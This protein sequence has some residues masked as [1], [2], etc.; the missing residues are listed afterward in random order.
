MIYDFLADA[1]ITTWSEYLRMILRPFSLLSEASKA[2]GYVIGQSTD[3]SRIRTEQTGHPNF[4]M[5]DSSQ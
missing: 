3:C 5:V 1:H 2:P 4:P